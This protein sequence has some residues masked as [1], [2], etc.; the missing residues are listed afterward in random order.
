[1]KPY[2]TAHYLHLS[3]VAHAWSFHFRGVMGS[4]FCSKV[5]VLVL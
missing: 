5:S 3:S 4:L 2:I 1:M